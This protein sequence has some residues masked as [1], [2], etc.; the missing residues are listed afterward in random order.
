MVFATAVGADPSTDLDYLDLSRGPSVLPTFLG[1]RVFREGQN[2][3][4]WEPWAFDPQATFT[5]GCDMSFHGRA[6]SANDDRGVVETE[7]TAVWDKG[8]SALI[9]TDT[10][11]TIDGRLVVLGDDDDVGPRPRRLRR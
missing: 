3:N 4:L 8:S 5:L 11:V 9:V 1:A 10:A 2:L 6:P 7:A